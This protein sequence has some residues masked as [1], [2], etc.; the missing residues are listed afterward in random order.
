MSYRDDGTARFVGLQLV[1]G[2]IEDRKGTFVL[3]TVG[4]FD[5]KQATWKAT[6]V[7]GSGTGDLEGLRGKAK[8]GAPKGPNATFDFDNE[9]A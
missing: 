6:V 3:E 1:R 4:D 7:P 2:A 8:F 5:G 9:L